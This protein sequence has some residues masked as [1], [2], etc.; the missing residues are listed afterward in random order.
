LGQLVAGRLTRRLIKT[1]KLYFRDTGL[2]CFLLG[3]ESPSALASSLLSGAV[4]ETF[5]LGQI[6][7][8]GPPRST[9]SPAARRTRTPSPASPE[10][11]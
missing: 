10:C 5:V 11:G 2:L 1:P 6:L 9:G 8:S 3:L 4:W 7:R